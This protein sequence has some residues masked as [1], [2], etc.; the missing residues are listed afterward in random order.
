MNFLKA[1][2]EGKEHPLMHNNFTR[3][4]KGDY[5][6]LYFEIKK[7][8]DLKIKSSFDFANGFVEIIS[9][10]IK[11]DAEVSGKIIASRDFKDELGI[12]IKDF[13]KRGKLFTAEIGTKLSPQ[14]L[15][16]VYDKMKEEFLLLKIESNNFK[17][18]T[19]NSLPKPGGTIKPNFCSAA[20]PLD[21]LEEF[22]WDVK[23]DFKLLIIRHV[24]HIT[25]IKFSPELMKSDPA[26]ARL[27]AK[28][29]GKIERIL[30]I[31]GKEEKKEAKLDA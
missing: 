3:Y 6:R 26:R 7:G 22:A 20:L 13:S 31:G 23:D 14:Q 4:G 15:K 17:L 27:E 24:L 25:D 19:A 1:I 2:F 11:G 21:C 10:K 12:E 9:E 5:E 16:G 30:N 18:K 8:K 28:R 29:I